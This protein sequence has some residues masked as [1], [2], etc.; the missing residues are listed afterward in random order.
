MGAWRVLAWALSCLLFLPIPGYAALFT[1]GFPPAGT[2]GVPTSASGGVTFTA[3]LFGQT[4]EPPNPP[5]GTGIVWFDAATQRIRS[6]NNL[7]VISTSVVSD[8]GAPNNFLTG[9]S[10]SGIV[11]KA[12]PAFTNIFGTAA[13][14]QLPNPTTSLKGGV[15][16]KDCTGVGHVLSINAD[17]TVT[18]SA[19]AG[20][21]G[22]L[23]DPGANGVVVRTSAGTTVARTVTGTANQVVVTNGTGVAGNPTLSLPQDIDTAAN[24]QHGAL[25]LGIT[26]PA[27]DGML[28]QTGAANNLTLHTIRRNTDTAPTGNFATYQNA[29][30]T[31]LW[32]VDITGSLT[33]GTIPAARVSSGQIATANGGTNASNTATTGRFLKGNGTAFVTSSGDAAGIGSCT[34]QVVTALNS[35]A[36]P[37]CTTITS[38]Y[39][40][41]SIITSAA[42]QT[43]SNKTMGNSNVFTMR[44]DR[45]TL[46]DNAD[47][48]KQAVFQLSGITPAN[49]REVTI[50]DGA[51]ATV[52]ADAGAL[53]NFL[54]AI[55]ATGVVSKARPSFG[56]ISGTVDTVQLPNPLTNAKGAVQAKDCTGVGHV[57]SI[58][59]DS[60]VTCSADASVG[61]GTPAGS[62]GSVQYNAAGAFG[63]S[64]GLKVDGTTVVAR[65]DK[66]T[67]ISSNTAL[68]DHNIVYV[69]VGAGGVTVTLPSAASTTVGKYDIIIADT[70]TGNL[71]LSPNGSDTLNGVNASKAR[72][73]RYSGYIVTWLSTTD[74]LV[75][76]I[77][78][79]ITKTLQVPTASC[80]NASAAPGLDLPTSNAPT[81]NCLT[82]TNTQ[83]ATLDFGDSANQTAQFAF[84]LP[85]GWAAPLDADL[86]WLVTTGGGSAAAQWTIATACEGVGGSFDPAFNTA[87]TITT[88]VSANNL[89]TKSTQTGV[90]TTGCGA[91]SEMHV[92][93]GRNVADTSTATL[94]LKNIV[95][96]MRVQPQP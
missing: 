16:A 94:R 87:Q 74:W 67:A 45:L 51:S 52:I 91:G 44:D 30:G 12:Q 93:I 88:N 70:G 32:N 2:P 63:G 36:V 35:D 72:T 83:Q 28:S 57:L 56:N 78:T 60:T 66:V 7:G 39:V 62:T 34:N 37:S 11:S 3:A 15:Q 23:G 43:L 9:I 85:A 90:T 96:T 4:A 5:L 14:A 86:F 41:T 8:P 47:T 65:K 46:Q 29:A 20:A 10:T 24:I 54:T 1:S 77:F 31:A 81:P 58:N 89:L 25:G 17:S 82:G 59:T 42:T 53:H 80:N 84:I 27:T 6:K 13:P 64:T 50:A 49:T 92:R 55:S 69:T 21:A 22:G 40:D 79:T 75:E 33:A 26:A 76:E 61:G 71:T 18:C 48:T 68:G 38:A 95:L 19:D 73:G